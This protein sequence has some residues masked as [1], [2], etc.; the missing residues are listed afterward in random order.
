MTEGIENLVRLV[1]EVTANAIPAIV[2]SLMVPGT[3]YGALIPSV[4]RNI[5]VEDPPR[6]FLTR[7]GAE[8]LSPFV[9]HKNVLNA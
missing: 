8:S 2:A 4:C 3:K 6:V 9:E 7:S 1:G 5:Y